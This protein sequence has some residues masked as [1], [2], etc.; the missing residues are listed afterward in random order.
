MASLSPAQR[1]WII[2]ALIFGAMVLN[3]V[4]RQI[5]SVLK[6]TL[7]IEYAL[8]DNGYATLVNA[9]TLCYAATYPVAGWLADRYGA[10][11]I[12]LIGIIA[13]SGVCIGTAFTKTFA[14]FA[15]LRGALG[16]VETL[17]YPAQLRI[18]TTWF[19]PSLRATANSI[20]AAGSTIGAVAAPALVAWLALA[21]H[22]QAAFVVPGLLGW[23]VA[24]LWWFFYRTPPA[25]VTAETVQ[26]AE[27]KKIEAY[28]WPRLWKTRTL[29]GIIL[30]RFVSDPVWYFC[31]FWLPGYLQES[32]G[33]SLHAIGLVGWIPFL[34]ADLGGIGSSALSDRLVRRGI[35]PLRA[36]KLVLTG[37]AMLAPLCAIT[38]YLSSATATLVIFS[39]IG[40]VCLTWLFNMGVVVAESFPAPNVGSVWGIA[41]G[42]GALGSILFNIYIGHLMQTVGSAKIFLVMALLH[43]LAV[44]LLWTMTRRERPQ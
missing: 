21:F 44:V 35:E 43:P 8:D 32:S 33:L 14:Q 4:D 29:W 13:W 3:Y 31:L 28:T 9:F 38:P 19:P 30:I 10:G 17:A 39:L 36:R 37:A 6:P 42:F 1:R 2:L 15:L 40:A 12:M 27:L 5:V 25:E 34:V 41:A 24:L 16:L 23:G 11:R 18:V 20:C 22:W 7:K 26:A